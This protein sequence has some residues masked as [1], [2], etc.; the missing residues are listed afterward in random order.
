MPGTVRDQL[1]AGEPTF[2]FEFFP[3]KDEGS[4]AV[5]WRTLRELERLR[6][7]FVS[8]TYGAGGTTR[9]GTVRVTERI[10]TQTTMLPMAHLTAVNHSVAELRNVIGGFAAVG[11]RNILAIR[12]DPPGDPSATWIKH[13][14]GIEY[15]DELVGIVR[16]AGDFCVGVAAFPYKHPRSADIHSDARY[17]VQKV[18]A[19]ADFAITQM[20]FDAEDYLRLRDRVSV[21]G[22]D[23]PIIPGIM[24]VTSMGTIERAPKLSGAPFPPALAA[25][26]E[27]IAQDKDAVRAQGVS[28]ASA[29]CQ[30]LLDEGAPGIHFITLNRSTATREIWANLRQTAP[31]G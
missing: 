27:P 16:R 23:V 8:V 3:P 5:L 18:Q 9:E 21:L 15:A 7:S 22:C 4:E 28:Q 25:T 11:V 13:P 10:A 1:A 29:L 14:K 26:F 24:P 19:G 12:G 17:F 31:T 20:F 30:R 2:S 6:P